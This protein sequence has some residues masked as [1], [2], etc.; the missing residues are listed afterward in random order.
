LWI[1]AP[2][3]IAFLTGTVF[4]F[5]I[6]LE[7]IATATLCGT[8]TCG[9]VTLVASAAL[10]PLIFLAGLAVALSACIRRARDAGLRTRLG[11]FPPLLMGEPRRPAGGAPDRSD[12]VTARKSGTNSTQQPSGFQERIRHHCR[13]AAPSLD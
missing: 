4:V 2:T 5:P 6:L 1:E 12:A 8:D 7:A 13:S 10:R 11:A 3:R 9:A